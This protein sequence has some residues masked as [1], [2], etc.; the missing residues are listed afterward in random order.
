MRRRFAV[1]VFPELVGRLQDAGMSLRASY[2]L[3]VAGSALPALVLLLLAGLSFHES[4]HCRPVFSERL[5]LKESLNQVLRV[6]P[7]RRF[8][9]GEVFMQF[10][11]N[12]VTLGMLYYTVVIF[13]QEQRF[14]TV[15]AA[16][17]F[18]T[19]LVAFPLVNALAKKKG[20]IKILT[21]S[22]LVLAFCALGVFLLSFNMAGIAFYLGVALFA[23]AGIPTAAFS[24]L[25]NPTIAE[26]ARSQ[27]AQTGG[28]RE[29]IFFGAR[30]VPLKI[31]IAIAG[32]VF[33]FLLSTYG[34][35]IA[36]PLGVQLTLFLVA[37]ASLGAF[38]TF[39]GYPEKE[40]QKALAEE[41]KLY[42]G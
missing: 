31:T 12:L 2:R 21:A 8:I 39:R 27:A 38:L 6:L 29:A 18:G 5:G 32:G 10:S 28:R 19:A 11:M 26:I 33:G 7:F 37:L 22:A 40:V 17:V 1:V 20:K 25:V 9:I 34:R 23:L 3:G 36:E 41:E 14:M 30:A 24:I 4:R 13:R 16:L 15:L 35:D 42:G